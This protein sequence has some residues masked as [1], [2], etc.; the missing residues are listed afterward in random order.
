VISQLTFPFPVRVIARIL[1]LPEASRELRGYL[2]E[3]RRHTRDDLMS[4]PIEAEVDG[5]RLSDEE[6]YPFA[7]APPTGL[8]CRL[9]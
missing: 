5:R 7:L 2:A 3:R 4:Q 8:P 1:G 9:A 6:I